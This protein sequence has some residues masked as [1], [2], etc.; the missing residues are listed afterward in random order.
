LKKFVDASEK[1]ETLKLKLQIE[2]ID[3]TKSIVNDYNGRKIKA[4]SKKQTL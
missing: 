4:K 1:I 3:T 2:T